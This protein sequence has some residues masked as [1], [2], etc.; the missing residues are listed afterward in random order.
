MSSY[1]YFGTP[2]LSG[3][4]TFGTPLNVVYCPF[5]AFYIPIRGVN[6]GIESTLAL[7]IDTDGVI[8]IAPAPGGT[9]TP[10]ANAG[11]YSFS[12]SWPIS[13]V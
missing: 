6:N 1:F 7:V 10:G 5:V 9:F 2:G 11:Y 12:A 4:V 13:N 3:R 8:T